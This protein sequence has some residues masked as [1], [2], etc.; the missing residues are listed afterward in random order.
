LISQENFFLFTPMLHE[1]AAS[2]LDVTLCTGIAFAL[3][4]TSYELALYAMNQVRAAGKTISFDPSLRPVLWPSKAGISLWLQTRCTVLLAIADIVPRIEESV[5]T[6]DILANNAGIIRRQDALT[7][8]MADWD[9]VL[10]VNLKAVFLDDLRFEL[11][12]LEKTA[13]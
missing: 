1:V 11:P 12:P 2:D 6:L 13:N 4:P 8:T 9:D 10:D 5:P 3:S 7:M